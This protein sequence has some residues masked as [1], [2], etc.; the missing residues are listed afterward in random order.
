[1]EVI[2][3]PTLV[4]IG[5]G[6][7]IERS[8]VI[9][10]INA[11]SNSLPLKKYRSSMFDRGMLV[12]VTKGRRVKAFILTD[13]NHLFLSSINATTIKARLEEDGDGLDVP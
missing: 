1:V 12:D 7:V 2:S 13:S 5:G 3:R 11:A 9:A 4:L 10:V 6:T 8:R